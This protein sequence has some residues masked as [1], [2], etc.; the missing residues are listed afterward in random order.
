MAVDLQDATGDTNLPAL[1]EWSRW[2]TVV[3]DLADDLATD[4]VAEANWGRQAQARDRTKA[5]RRKGE[6]SQ[7]RGGV[8]WTMRQ[9]SAA[10]VHDA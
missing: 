5:C 9:Y 8:A 10:Q 2:A 7:G 1:A 4:D 6:E 3:L